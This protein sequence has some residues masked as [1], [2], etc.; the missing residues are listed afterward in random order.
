MKVED[1][2]KKAMRYGRA[3]WA[4]GNSKSWGRQSYVSNR[5]QDVKRRKSLEDTW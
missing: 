5:S 4:T 2:R 3:L 1:E